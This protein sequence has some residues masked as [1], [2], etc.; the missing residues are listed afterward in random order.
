MDEEMPV[1]GS[2]SGRTRQ[3]DVVVKEGDE[4]RITRTLVE[5]QTRRDLLTKCRSLMRSGQ[6]D[7]A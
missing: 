7:E 2:K 3:C 5:V 6:P 4:P 1:L